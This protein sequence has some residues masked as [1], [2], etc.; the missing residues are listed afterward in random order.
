[1]I[2]GLEQMDARRGEEK[3]QIQQKCIFCKFTGAAHVLQ[4]KGDQLPPLAGFFMWFFHAYR[5]F[6]AFAA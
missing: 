1:M 2:G 4:S 5:S 3:P 6:L